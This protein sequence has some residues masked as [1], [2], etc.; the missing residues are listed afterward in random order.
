[1]IAFSYAILQR[2]L[3]RMAT[4]FGI[5]S[6]ILFFVGIVALIRPIPELKIGTRQRALL[7]VAASFVISI[8]AAFFIE[9]ELGD[10]SANVELAKD[11]GRSEAVYDF[12]I[13]SHYVGGV[14]IKV[15][16]PMGLSREEIAQI[17]GNAA[18]KYGGDGDVTVWVY[19]DGDDVDA[20][21][22]T[23]AMGDRAANAGEFKL[24]FSDAYF[25]VTS[26]VEHSN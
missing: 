5:I 10:A 22:Y 21:G 14:G 4:L 6:V 2:R 20:S 15:K 25:G 11:A 26:K 19:R 3:I 12:V 16:V 24:A 17:I 13:R 18:S 23:V 1:M 7:V 9:N 8:G